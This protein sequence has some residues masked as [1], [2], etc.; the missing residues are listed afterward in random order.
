MS[1]V[2][3]AIALYLSLGAGTLAF[4][5]A[6]EVWDID[7]DSPF[8]ALLA[9]ATTLFWPITLPVALALSPDADGRLASPSKP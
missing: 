8:A 2:L 7:G 1:K 3:E 4:E 9:Y 5:S 6:H